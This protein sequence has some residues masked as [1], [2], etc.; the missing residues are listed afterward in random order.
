NTQNYNRYSYVLN[1]PLSLT[2][3]TGYF[4]GEADMMHAILMDSTMGNNHMMSINSWIG[5]YNSLELKKNAEL[6]EKILKLLAEDDD[7]S[8]SGNGS[9]DGAQSSRESSEN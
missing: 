8:G 7:T 1:N 5:Y 2:D 3:P 9:S 4:Y 6:Q